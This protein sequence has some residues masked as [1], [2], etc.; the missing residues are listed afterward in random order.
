MYFSQLTLPPLLQ[1][2]TLSQ[3]GIECAI[4]RKR[5]VHEE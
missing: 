2:L 1:P 4:H 5:D 3:H